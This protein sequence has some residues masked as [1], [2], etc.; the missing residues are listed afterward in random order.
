MTINS[1]LIPTDG[2]DVA[3]QTAHSGL[4]LAT[5]FDAE[6]HVI[7]V[8]DS[9][10]ATGVGYSGD[11][12]R[13]RRRL[14]E[15]ATERA[16]SLGQEAAARGINVT[17][18]IRE[19]IPAQ[20]IIEY[21]TDHDLDGIVIGTSGRGG[22]SRALIGSV[23]DKVIR[24]ATI[25]VI[26]LNPATLDSESTFE[27]IES[28][29]LPTDGSGA[30]ERAAVQGIELADKLDAMVH[31]LSVI[32]PTDTLVEE[33]EPV[34]DEFA[35]DAISKIEQECRDRDLDVVTSIRSGKPAEEIVEYVSENDTGGIVIGTQGHGGFTR[36]LLG[37]VTD[38][39]VRTAPVPVITIRATGV[40]A[41]E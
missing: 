9:S 25:P 2:S 30:S 17:T 35:I 20:E 1:L 14:R 40:P 38:A 12:P 10:L 33:G 11:S 15:Q 16:D 23:A 7:S 6:V 4:D 26:T 41:N 24:T 18:A 34:G 3:T 27:N 36:W 29:L 5:Q 13:M 28:L 21:A 37:S 22:V 19:G 8:A 31:V 32:E 39:V